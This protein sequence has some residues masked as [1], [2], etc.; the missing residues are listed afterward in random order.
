MALSRTHP[1]YQ[2]KLAQAK[3][4]KSEI[5]HRIFDVEQFSNEAT[6]QN[7]C[8][9]CQFWGE[10]VGDLWRREVTVTGIEYAPLRCF[11]EHPEYDPAVWRN[12]P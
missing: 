10:C 8:Y 3:A 6:K 12:R 5:L 11:A 4:A 9:Q 1:A 2:K 7:G